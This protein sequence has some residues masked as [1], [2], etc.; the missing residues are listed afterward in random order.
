MTR[1]LDPTTLDLTGIVRPGD[2]IVWGNATGEPQTLTE[3]LVRQRRDLGGVEVFVGASFSRTLQP[4]HADHLR[5]RGFGGIGTASELAKAGVLEIVPCHVGQIA[6]YIAD[7]RIGCDVAF[8]QVSPPGPDGRHSFG[9]A[10]DYIPTAVDVARV[11]VA[12]VNDQ[13]PWTAGSR[14]LGPDDIDFAVRT[15]RPVLEVKPSV[16]G[17]LERAIARHASTY[18][19]D[20]SVLQVGIGGI[21]DAIL[22]SIGDRRDLGLHSGMVGDAFVDLVQAGVLTN[23]RKT[24]DPGVSIAGLLIGTRR[25]YDFAHGNRALAM[26]ES[27]YTHSE[28]VLARVDQLVSINSAIEVDLTGQVNAE[29]AGAAYV[30]GTGGQ[31][32]Y[33]RAGHRSRGGRSIIAFASTAKADTVSR[34][35]LQL[36]GP[37]TTARSDVDVIVTEYGAADLRAQPLRERAR[38]L[39]AI[40]HPRFREELE[41]G[42]QGLLQRGY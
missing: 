25:L 29:A 17:E 37:V 36:G 34:I 11:V 6:Q 42:A 12:E 20:G 14:S 33:V 35:C 18:I 2:R 26:R 28:A 5:M 8:V 23:A 22:Q 10:H 27:S 24:I 3:T 40:A 1:D 21:P 13:V 31:V 32:D 4:E 30:G 38:R 39:I 41:R 9:V 7:R 15:S 19:E 16:V